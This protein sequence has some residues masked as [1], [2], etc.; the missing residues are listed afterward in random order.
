MEGRKQGSAQRRA[1]F[2]LVLGVL[3]C[4]G[5]VA[6]GAF[7]MVA[8]ITGT[9]DSTSTDTTT[10]AAATDPPAAPTSIDWGAGTAA[11][12]T[13]TTTSTPAAA[14]NPSI[15]S[16]AGVYGP[17]ATVTLTSSG[18]L[19]GERVNL[20]VNDDQGKTWSYST[21]VSAG[22]D[23]SFTHQFQLP[24]NFVAVYSVTATGA[25]G[26]TATTQF[27]DDAVVISF[28]A[29]S[30]YDSNAWGA[31]CPPGGFCGTSNG[32]NT[33]AVKVSIRQGSG[34][35]WNG[36]TFGSSTETFFATNLT[37]T[38]GNNSNWSLAFPFGSFANGQYTLHVQGFDGSD[39]PIK[40]DEQSVTFTIS[41]QQSTSLSVTAASGTYGGTATLSASLTAGGSGM[42]GKAISFTLNGSSVGS[43]TTNSSG[44]ATL[45]ASLA[46]INAGGY[47]SGV[48]ASFAGDGSFSGSTGTGSLTIAKAGQTITFA[49]PSSPAAYGSSPAVN[50]TASSGLLVAI[51]VTG[52][53]TYNGSVGTVT[54]TSGS[55][56]CAI[57]A[58]Q[59]G[60]GNYNAATSVTRSVDAAKANQTITIS[61]HAPSS[62]VYNTTFGVAATATSNMPVTFGASGSCMNSGG[63]FTMTSG[64]GAC[65]VKYDQAGDGNYNTAP[66]L[67]ET[68]NAAKASQT[69]TFAQ[70]ASPA[71]Y[72]ATFTANPT[73]DSGLAVQVAASG[74][75]SI[76]GGTVTMTTGTGACTL[77]AS[78]GGS[79][80]YTAAT[81]VVRTVDAAKAGQAITFGPLADKAYGNADFSVS[82][83]ATS[84]LDVGFSASGDCSVSDSAVHIAAAGSCTITASQ[85]GN[86]NYGPAPAVQRTFAIAKRG[87]TVAAED[88]HIQYPADRPAFTVSYDGFVNG[89]GAGSLGGSLS[90]DTTPDSTAT[91]P[92]AG[93]Y[94]IGCSGLTS[95]NYDITYKPGTLTVDKGDQTITF[96]ALV[97]KTYG[98]DDVS[99]SASASS[100][101]PVGFSASGDCSVSGSTVHITGAGS[102]A[103]MASQGGNGDWNAA[104][105]VEQSFSIAKHALTATADDKHIQYPANRPALTVSYDGFVNGDGPA[106]LGGS[107][108]CATTPAS[109]QSSPHAGSYAIN[110]SGLTSGNYDI[111]YKPGTLTVD[112]GDQM[113]TFGA[114]ADKTYGDAAVDL[115]ASAT[116]GL[117]VSFAA[118]GGH[119][120]VVTGPKLR[121]DSAGSCTVTASQGGNDDWNAAADVARTF[122]I[123]KAPLS[124]TADDK[125][126]QYPA[127]RAAFTVSYDGFVNGDTADSLGGPLN[128]AT[129]PDSTQDSPH[130]GSYAIDCQG[131]TSDN[132]EITYHPGTLTVEK[133]DQTI[134]FAALADTTYGDADF[135]V[136]ASASSG[137]PVGF[138]S[139]GDCSIS[140]P[141]VHITG[142]GSCTIAAS[143]A[144]ND[145]WKAATNVPQSF[146]IAKHTLTV[147]AD[148][149]HITHPAD[150]PAF[151]V[152]YDG[153]VNGDGPGS[154]GDSLS[155]DTT[156]AS[157]ASSPHAGS[158]AIDCSGLS[159][160]NYELHYEAGTLTVDKGDQAITFPAIGG[161]VYLDADFDPGASAS[162]GLPVGY[163]IG[164]G[165]QCTIVGGKV[166]ITGAG[167]CTVTAS[168]AGNG[169][170][171][172]ATSV[173]RTFAI[174][175]ADQ[176]IA[177]PAIADHVYLDGDFDPGASA[178]SG[179][180]VG[181]S[182]GAGDQCT[183]VGGKVH[184][185]GAGS[186]TVTASQA[187]NA[188]YNAAP[189]VSRTL[190]IAKADQTITF[191]ALA[192][193][194]FGDDDFTVGATSSSGLDVAFGVGASDNCTIGG[195]TIHITGAGS[196][197]VTARQG[198]NSN[199]NA[200]PDVARTFSIAKR[201]T[202]VTAT[203][204]AAVTLGQS[205]LAV[206]ALVSANGGTAQPNGGT[207][208][209]SL[210]N[211]SGT[212]VATASGSVSGGS[213]G[214]NLAIASLPVGTYT[215][216][217]SYSGT[218][219]F[220]GSNNSSQSPATVSDQYRWDGFLQPIN[221]TAHQ[222][223]QSTSVFKAGSTVPAKFQL[224]RADGTVVQAATPPVW[225]TP[226]KGN[227]MSS[228]V[229]ETVYADPAS[230][231]SSFA[232]DGTQYQY[233]WSTK[234]LAAGY[235]YK[236]C[237]RFDDGQTQ[238]V[239]IGLR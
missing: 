213:A 198:G 98:D 8:A 165:D 47:A 20:F 227:A 61:S 231:G 31:G 12:D 190:A 112:K 152:S 59:S 103:V 2:V 218:A 91:G 67:T 15:S 77:T 65:T 132:Y 147:S 51:G 39:K 115:G 118:S 164:A 76:S 177:F 220:N 62:A 216:L 42:S 193:K 230:S 78:Q 108:S 74:A 9:T 48:G 26:E 83:S 94:A 211:S 228:P 44:T 128:C 58:S 233:N 79:A 206:S 21:D 10:T 203:T 224:K 202:S 178:S 99:L 163:S 29:A 13:T 6:S 156:P 176:T 90:C 57:T 214:G 209:F 200:A 87:L 82:A 197:T 207:A 180:P 81:N 97:N 85:A 210:K 121:L 5:F 139:S 75:C 36:S 188:N 22:S 237:A 196:C 119:C 106:S 184:I 153:F 130:A 232:W 64:S 24:S 239:N 217:A 146:S 151:T 124:V 101:L 18:W 221:D 183:I 32:G 225:L 208:S 28:P 45:S 127:D 37:P 104:Q 23:G 84:G 186:C 161:H 174:A 113:I 173:S 141:S 126:I 123:A 131:Q 155:C 80:N 226:V 66:E 201:D 144:G 182:I 1:K 137:L 212:V 194:T 179:L 236:I 199:Y 195:A 215:L 19:S 114:L 189:A 191:N 187:G 95:G 7:G 238:C 41:A 145:D 142:A 70:P 35:Y 52:P 172:A 192:G 136:S 160:G 16:D 63:T 17:G 100:G 157:T 73:S 25:N 120:T 229:D 117:P 138:A 175:K 56:T 181:Y 149:K 89:D 53:C 219:N 111:T 49:Q 71:V 96:G 140:G 205:S 11:T 234:G 223:G 116:S 38:G 148:D 222:V 125:Q 162:S 171:N 50:A 169:D 107:L 154:L 3:L 122:S 167:S 55:G 69:I 235:W 4:A 33:A 86:G 93:S 158:Y 105:D 133:G 27:Q 110:C 68:V 40:N 43:A 135:A 170:W 134:T 54:M 204:T 14:A 129:T 166:H 30:S 92:H 102:C 150:R 159:S 34:D 109:S 168:Q 88:K 60:D 72:G 185:T 46:G 143:Q